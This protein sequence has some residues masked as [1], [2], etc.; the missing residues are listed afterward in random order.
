VNRLSA[1]ILLSLGLVVV[2]IPAVL[3]APPPPD[4]FDHSVSEFYTP[5]IEQLKQDGI[6]NDYLEQIFS[7]S[8]SRFYQRLTQVHLFHKETADPYAKMQNA[9]SIQAIREFL[10]RHKQI[11]DRIEQ[12]YP[13]DRHVIASILYV[14][15]R[16]GN[17]P[18]R[19]PV[20]YVLSSMSLASK[21]WSIRSLLER[22]DNTFPDLS[23]I[24]R[25]RK[26]TWIKDRAESKASWAYEELTT[27]LKLRESHNLDVRSLRGSWAGAFGIPQ[28]LPSSYKAYA[29]DGDGDGDVDLYS[30]EDAI[31]SVAN[32]LYHNGWRSKQIS[33]ERKRRAI[34]RYNHSEHYVS[35]IDT[36]SREARSG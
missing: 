13:V 4:G 18:G 12:D 28:F 14:E 9:Q 2:L 26:I 30:M 7:S 19:H 29:V 24:E 20:V 15:S 32:Y 17:S 25:Q 34:W 1:G 5:L 8:D 21:E 10:A 22:L 31:A 6:S 27:L 16:F 11:F 35:C 33:D 36:L 3:L 23:A